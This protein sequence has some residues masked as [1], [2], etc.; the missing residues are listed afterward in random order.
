MRK[1]GHGLDQ[2]VV[3]DSERARDLLLGKLTERGSEQDRDV[4]RVVAIAG[5]MDVDEDDLPRGS[6]VDGVVGVQIAMHPD[7]ERWSKQFFALLACIVD[8]RVKNLVK[9]ANRKERR[10][11]N[12][13]A[14]DGPGEDGAPRRSLE[15][16]P[17]RARNPDE[18]VAME[19]VAERYVAKLPEELQPFA[20]AYL[21]DELQKATAERLG[22]S[23]R[24]V[25]RNMNLIRKIWQDMAAKDFDA[26]LA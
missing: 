11:A 4:T 2:H 16:A 13:A 3:D 26:A 7:A 12:E 21:D 8:C 24:Q 22:C 9:M 17:D 1:L 19:D 23:E 6:V 20:Q 10:V 18:L 5:A 14:M 25:Q 15:R